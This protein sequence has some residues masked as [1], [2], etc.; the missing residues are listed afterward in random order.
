MLMWPV[1]MPSFKVVCRYL[2]AYTGGQTGQ[3][4][5]QLT[6]LDVGPQEPQVVCQVQVEAGRLPLEPWQVANCMQ[7]HLVR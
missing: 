3:A 4:G 7:L 1:H 5:P 6:V 2:A